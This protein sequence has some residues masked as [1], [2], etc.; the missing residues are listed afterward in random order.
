M[1]I[2]LIGP[3]PLSKSGN[4]HAIVAVDYLTKWVITKAVP[5]ADSKELVDFLVHRV[6]LQHGA[7]N[8]LI[9]D[10]GKCLTLGFSKTLYKAMQTNHL[11]TTA[12]HPQCNGLVERFNHT[13]AEMLSIYVNTS[14]ADWDE[15]VDFVT[16]AYNTSRQESTGSTPFYLLYGREAVLPIDVA[17]GNDPNPSF[18]DPLEN[19]AVSLIQRLDVI[20][21][22]VKRRIMVVQARQKKRYDNKRKESSHQ[23][24]D[25]VLV[26]RPTRKKGRSEKLLHQFHGPFT[27][28]KKLS[29][30]T[31]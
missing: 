23:V 8:F 31:P 29:D 6:V 21:E 25:Q 19:N 30:L 14:H 16:F 11:T 7:P 18:V 26:F 1:G 9:S 10:R 24:G 20:R 5:T 15:T 28:V 3:F 12:Y 13:F 22:K 2:D 17:L 4:R 27:V